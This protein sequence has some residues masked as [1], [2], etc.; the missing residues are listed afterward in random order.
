MNEAS[1]ERFAVSGLVNNVELQY[2]L[3]R[4]Q[5]AARYARGKIVLDVAC[6]TG[7]GA[8]MLSQVALKAVGA[9]VS[10]ASLSFARDQYNIANLKFVCLDA[11]KLPFGED[12]FEVVTS[13]ETLEHLVEPEGFLEECVRVLRPG[14]FLVLSTPNRDSHFWPSGIAQRSPLV[15]GLLGRIK[16]LH[17]ALVNPFHH[18]EF[19]YHELKGI[20]GPRLRIVGFF[21]ISKLS[22]SWIY[23][24]GMAKIPGIGRIWWEATKVIEF[25]RTHVK[26]G[27]FVDAKEVQLRTTAPVEAPFI[28]FPLDRPGP[29]EYF[30]I[31][32]QKQTVRSAMTLHS[33]SSVGCVP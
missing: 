29:V 11:H 25:I 28:P 6:G 22:R 32:G 15:E 2:H 12:S 1:G 3:S 5:F 24:T 16:E 26:S 30:I 33:G 10:F 7:Y 4:Y 8:Y 19:D 14:G 21:G 23:T 20:V 31:V 9:D 18:R 13:L 17:R 27:P